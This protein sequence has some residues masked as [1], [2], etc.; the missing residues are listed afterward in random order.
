MYQWV[1]VRGDY[2]F[3]WYWWNCC[4]SLFKLFFSYLCIL[5]SSDNYHTIW[6]MNHYLYLYLY[7]CVVVTNSGLYPTV[8]RAPSIYW[9]F[10]RADLKLST[11]V[12]HTTESSRWFQLISV[13]TKNEFENWC[14]L[15]DGMSKHFVLFFTC[16][17]MMLV[18]W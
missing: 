9:W 5:N 8:E 7:E 10:V 12:A 16:F 6:I 14:V 18:A 17:S 3:S 4:S 13:F 15:L 1:E 2:S 11:L